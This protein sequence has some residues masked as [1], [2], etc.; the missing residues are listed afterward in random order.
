MTDTA[1]QTRLTPDDFPSLGQADT[2]PWDRP[3]DKIDVS[4]AEL[5]ETDTMWGY[6]ERLR[7]E[8]PV[9]YC[10]ESY[11]GPFWSVTRY[12]DIVTMEKDTETF[13][14]DRAI[15][16]NDPRPDF[17]LSPGFIAMDG[18]RHQRHRKT[19]QPV[20][21]PK[22]LRN[23]EPVIRGRVQEMLDGLPVGETFDWVDKV[24]IELTTGMLA[25]I[26]DFPWEDRRKLTYWSDMTTSTDQQ[27]ADMGLV[28]E[29]RQRILLECL[30]YF[31]TLWR[32]RENTDGDDEIDF[33]TAMANSESTRDIDPEVAPLDYLG[34]LIL[35][36]VGGNDTTR[37]SV[38]GGVL[39]LNENPAEYDKLRANPDL[40]PSMANE[41][42]RWQTPLAYMRRTATC[43]TEL[44][45]KQIKQG[46]KLAMWYVSANRDPDVF[47]RA[48]DFIIDRDKPKPHLSFGWGAHF[49]MG[50]RLAELQLRVLWEEILERFHVVEVV[51]DP[52]RVKSS[53]V[54]GYHELP[55]QLHPR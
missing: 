7:K 2:D 6:F 35:L 17:P 26:F 44:G 36:I 28:Q 18:E 30:D 51:G 31:T 52:V 54:K 25:T 20:A 1:D 32:D 37:N 53:F 12:D 48:D 22:N 39:A 19:V 14:S 24:S 5:F 46:E 41:I 21:A 49:C 50:S 11:L 10:P 45:G 27:L 40:I 4:D 38:S 15:T 16:L 34:T 13:S 42:I 29:D 8:E 33:I 23:L 3:L 43:D 9:H 55:V 47:D